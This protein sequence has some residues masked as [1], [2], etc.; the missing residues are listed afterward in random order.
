M[1]INF[2]KNGF[3]LLSRNNKK[4]FIAYQSIVKISD[5]YIDIDD[6]NYN[7]Y[8]RKYSTDSVCKYAA[9]KIY[10]SNEQTIEIILNDGYRYFRRFNKESVS[11]LSWLRKLFLFNPNDFLDK[12]ATEWLTNSS[13]DMSDPFARTKLLREEFLEHFNQW[14]AN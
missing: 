2:L 4:T 12:E 11:K 1:E 7:Y 9:F 13:L 14:K 6:R 10:L 5:V 8:E 3:E